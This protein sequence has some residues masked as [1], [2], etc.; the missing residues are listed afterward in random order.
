MSTPIKRTLPMGFLR[1]LIEISPSETDNRTVELT[2]STGF[3]GMRSGWDGS[4]YEELSMDPKHVDMSRLQ[5]GA[6]LLNS[7]DS[8][9]IN[10]VIGVV[11]RA[12]LS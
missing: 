1:S 6:P 4:F 12:G 5:S 8:S 2:W 10:S 9:N 3:K 7:H 11:E